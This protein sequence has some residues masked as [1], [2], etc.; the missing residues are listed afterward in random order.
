MSVVRV[1]VWSAGFVELCSS[2]WVCMSIWQLLFCIVDS[3]VYAAVQ[4]QVTY[5]VVAF[6]RPV[7]CSTVRCLTSIH[8]CRCLLKLVTTC[9]RRS[10]LVR[11]LLPVIIMFVV[12]VMLS[13][14]LLRRWPHP[15]IACCR[16]LALRPSVT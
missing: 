6:H 9:Y 16:L 4:L 14:S 3:W 7:A 2:E 8:C 10:S 11:H 15:S 1:I 12:N 13:R 5:W